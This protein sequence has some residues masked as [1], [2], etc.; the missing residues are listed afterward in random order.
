M[1]K[2]E[3]Q[4]LIKELE[5]HRDG[6]RDSLEGAVAA[7]PFGSVAVAFGVGTLLGTVGSVGLLGDIT[8]TALWNYSV[9]ASE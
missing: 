1:K 9:P 3:K 2:E 7:R 6:L 8:K 4:N 5:H